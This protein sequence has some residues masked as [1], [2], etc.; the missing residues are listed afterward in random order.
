VLTQTIAERL[1]LRMLAGTG[2]ALIGNARA[3]AAVAEIAG[4]L[5]VAASL[6]GIAEAAER[7]CADR[8]GS[9]G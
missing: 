8:D 4:R 9:V 5:E 2:I 3:A 1:A 6:I 7:L